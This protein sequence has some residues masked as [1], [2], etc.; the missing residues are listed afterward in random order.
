MKSCFLAVLLFTGEHHWKDHMCSPIPLPC[1][2][3]V[4]VE[5]LQG[6]HEFAVK[7]LRTMSKQGAHEFEAE[8]KVLSKLRHA[9]LVS[10]VG[11]CIEGKEMALVY[12]FMPN[13][14]LKD[15]LCK[16]DCALS[17]SQRLKI[18]IGAA[19]G[20]HYLHTGTSTQHGVIHRDVKTSNILHELM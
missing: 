10:L 14:T 18:C 12:E 4:Y 7:R 1:V 9:N 11:Y 5:E 15:H 8:V 2:G 13:G 17:W 6:A 3:A 16:A 19:R 20:L